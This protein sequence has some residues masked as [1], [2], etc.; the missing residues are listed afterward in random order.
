[1]ALDKVSKSDVRVLMLSATKRENFQAY[2]DVGHVTSDMIAFAE[3][4]K[5]VSEIYTSIANAPDPFSANLKL[6]PFTC[7]VL[8]RM[9]RPERFGE[10]L[11]KYIEH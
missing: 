9:L 4:V 1:M 7:L 2:A 6:K 10:V 5:N 8:V 3:A 11:D